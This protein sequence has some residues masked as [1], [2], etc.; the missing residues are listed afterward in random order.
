[1]D[2]IVLGI[3]DKTKCE[4]KIVR[5]I[6]DIMLFI[7]GVLMDAKFGIGSIFAVLIIG[8]MI[9]TFIRILKIN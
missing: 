3:A 8:T 9:N 4:Y 7:L 1:M 2:A 5:T 6:A